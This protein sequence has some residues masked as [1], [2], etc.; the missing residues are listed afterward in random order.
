MS[1]KLEQLR[2]FVIVAESGNIRDAAIRLDKTPSAISMSLK[3]TEDR[4]GSPLF[5]RDRKNALTPLG[6]YA[7]DTARHQIAGFDRAIQGILA[8]AGNAIGRVTVGCVSSVASRALPRL[9]QRFIDAHPRIELDVRDADSLAVEAL[10]ESEQVDLGIGLPP[11]RHEPVNFR[12]LY[13]ERYYLYCRTDDPLALLGRP[14]KWADIRDKALIL[15]AGSQ[16]IDNPEH[17][18]LAA[19]SRLFVRNL[20]SLLALVQAGTGVTVLPALDAVV[21]GPQVVGLPLA[22]P[23]ARQVIGLLTRQGAAQAPAV[24]AFDDLVIEMLGDPASIATG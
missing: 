3:H 19:R 21:H 2:I 13:A 20:T 10:V 11:T 24:R 15:N 16:G 17:R 7:Y 12:P 18:Q 14:V 6:R 9:L 5:E 23:L 8:Y 22:D 1:I 4:I